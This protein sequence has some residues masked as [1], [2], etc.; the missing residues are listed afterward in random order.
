MINMMNVDQLGIR[1]N[2][3]G[4]KALRLLPLVG[5]MK[6]GNHSSMESSAK[7]MLS[8]DLPY[9]SDEYRIASGRESDRWVRIGE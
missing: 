1:E 7:V 4:S 3:F 2:C 8:G 9:G 6:S 5:N